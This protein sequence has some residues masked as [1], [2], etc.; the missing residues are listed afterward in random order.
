M[1]SKS[2]AQAKLMQAVAHDPG[3]AAKVGVPVAVGKEF[4][5]ADHMRDLKRAAK[6]TPP[7][8]QRIPR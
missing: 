3:F 8:R 2:P 6:A 7:L 4:N 1:P 5:H